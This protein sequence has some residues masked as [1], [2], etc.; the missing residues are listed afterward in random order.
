MRSTL[1]PTAARSTAAAAAAHHATSRAC[2]LH[3]SSSRATALTTLALLVLGA[4]VASATPG[5]PAPTASATPTAPPA[6]PTT[7]AP[8][9]GELVPAQAA[10]LA[11]A[12]EIARLR[13]RGP[14]GLAEALA[15]Y[16]ELGRRSGY[17]LPAEVAR[18]EARV[19]AVA[20]QRHATV[21]R[22]YWYTDL[23]AAK[24][25]ATAS[26]KP[27]VSLRLLGRLDEELSCAN[28]RLFRATLYANAAIATLLREQVI[29]HWSS[30]RPV[31]RVTI[32]YGDGRTITTTTTGNSAHLV[33]D[34]SGA[35]LDVLPGVYAP[36]AFRTELTTSLA[37]ARRVAALPPAAGATALAAHHRGAAT[38]A[39]DRWRTLA[40]AR[41]GMMPARPEGSPARPAVG[42]APGAATPVGAPPPP[43]PTLSIAFAQLATVSKAAIEVPQL[44]ALRLEGGLRPRAPAD[45]GLW[46][47]L[48]RELWPAAAALDAPSR[49][50]VTRLH[51]AGPVTV[52]EAAVAAVITRLEQ[53]LLADSALDELVLRPAIHALLGT[54]EARLDVVTTWLYATVFHTPRGDAWLGLL[55]RTEFTGVPGDGARVTR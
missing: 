9:L 54:G 21:S 24:R 46:A 50:L 5:A 47:S 39:A 28:S 18:A 42:Y 27:I 53:N 33:L 3:T 35:V 1:R 40:A 11:E 38:A 29:L 16:D 22:L 23:D 31:P 49:A 10:A 8:G 48:G 41:G 12:H 32:D 26:G 43:P 17:V 51:T 7:A 14:A 34:A 44:R 2:S 4:S 19:D 13:A 52:P 6:T 55:P 45:V 37:L 20:A 25:A 36:G 30:E 15:A